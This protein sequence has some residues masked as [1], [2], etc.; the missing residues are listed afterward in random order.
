MCCL[1]IVISGVECKIRVS[2]CAVRGRTLRS[3]PAGR[4]LSSVT[5]FR[6]DLAQRTVK[7]V[8]SMRTKNNSYYIIKFSFAMSVRQ[9]SRG[10]EEDVGRSNFLGPNFTASVPLRETSAEFHSVRPA[11]GHSG[12]DGRP[13]P[14]GAATRPSP[15][16]QTKQLVNCNPEDRFGDVITP[17]DRGWNWFAAATQPD[18][19]Q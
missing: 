13:D 12:G 19:A 18:S 6:R 10:Q 16:P 8:D 11:Q 9:A 14:I 4:C 5:G 7:P 3:Y 1:S 2:R 17:F 15:L